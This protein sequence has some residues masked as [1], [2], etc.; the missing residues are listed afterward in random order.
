MCGLRFRISPTD[1]ML[2]VVRSAFSYVFL[3]ALRQTRTHHLTSLFPLFPTP[4][5]QPKGKGKAKLKAGGPIDTPTASTPDP[6]SNVEGEDRPFPPY[7]IHLIGKCSLSFGPMRFDEVSLWECRF[8][9]L[10]SKEEEAER[11]KRIQ[12]E[13]VSDH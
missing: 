12:V 5:P 2:I 7:A 11:K 9:V 13:K 1:S 3:Q 8:D 10:P 6:S 4:R